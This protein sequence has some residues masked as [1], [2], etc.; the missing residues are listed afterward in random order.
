MGKAANLTPREKEIIKSLRNEGKS[1]ADIARLVK[2]SKT[3]VYH[4]LLPVNVALRRGRPRKTTARFDRL[5]EIKVKSSPFLSSAELHHLTDA[6]VSF[7]TIRRRLQE[8]NLNSRSPR[9]VPLLSK[10]NIKDR[11]RFAQ[12]HLY[13]H[14]DDMLR[15][16]WQN[17]LW[18]DETKVNLFGSD[19]VGRVRR[20]PNKEFDCRYA[21]KTVKHGGGNIKV[22]GCFSYNG[23]GP[24][25]WIKETMTKETYRD[26]LTNVM[27]PYARQNM[28]EGWI[29]QHDN[30]PKH[31][32]GMVKNWLEDNQVTV[33]EWP[34]Q[35]PDLNPI[36]HL[37]YDL[38]KRLPKGKFINQAHLWIETQK[39]WNNIPKTA[40]ERLVMSMPRRCTE[41]IK[42]KGRTTRY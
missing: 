22:W 2:R 42:N 35:S 21:V 15:A 12:R 9:K 4:A 34:S 25:I 10:K 29:F 40:C 30:D 3:A 26:I 6:P 19:S 23:V 36:E 20:P 1:L 37:W 8:M 5:L 14:S 33:L 24:I 39:A 32:A 11:L 38:K 27:L 17:V 7:R 41:V 31:S 28:A 18:S 13:G 16:Q